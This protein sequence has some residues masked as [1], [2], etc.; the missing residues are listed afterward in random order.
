VHFIYTVYE[1]VSKEIYY[2]SIYTKRSG[3][4]LICVDVSKVQSLLYNGFKTTVAD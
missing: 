1:L 2:S 4:N 3:Q